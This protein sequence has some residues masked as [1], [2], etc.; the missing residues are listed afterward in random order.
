MEAGFRTPCPYLVPDEAILWPADSSCGRWCHHLT[1]PSDPSQDRPRLRR[2]R[3][4]HL[5]GRGTV[6]WYDT[7]SDFW[8]GL[9]DVVTFDERRLRAK[10]SYVLDSRRLDQVL[11]R[12]LSLAQ[13]ASGASDH[14]LLVADF[15]WHAVR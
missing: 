7:G 8:P 6:T 9:L 15:A 10:N 5:D 12:E 14:L 1:Q 2:R 3:L 4:L 11:R 13:D